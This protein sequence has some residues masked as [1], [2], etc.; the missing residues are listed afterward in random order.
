[1]SKVIKNSQDSYDILVV[2]DQVKIWD[3]IA[4]FFKPEIQ[5]GILNLEFAATG[6]ES[7][8]KIDTESNKKTDLLIID[9]ILPD[10][11]VNNE[12]FLID[13]LDRK[14]ENY[15]NKPSAFLVSAHM[16]IKN[17]E[18]LARNI[19]WIEE[20][21]I[22]P[23]DLDN[24]KTAIQKTLNLSS[25]KERF[26]IE[27][28]RLI[29]ARQLKKDV[30]EEIESEAEIILR[31]MKN[32]AA[33]V[34]DI[35]LRIN[36][37]KDKLPHGYFQKWVEIRLGCHYTTALNLLRVAQVFGDRQAELSKMGVVSS[38]LYHLATP[39]T[40]ELARTKVINLIES[41][42]KISY[43]ETKKIVRNYKDIENIE[44]QFEQPEDSPEIQQETEPT[45]NKQQVIPGIQ[46]ETEPTQNKQQI[47]K[48][49]PKKSNTEIDSIDQKSVNSQNQ[50]TELGTHRL[51]NGYPNSH[52]FQQQL[53]DKISLTIA[54]PKNNE[55][56][57]EELI[58]SRS[59]SEAIFYSPYKD[60]DIITLK[61]MVR[62]ALELYTEDKE[63]VVFSFMPDAQ[64][65]FIAE[66]LGCK[67][68]VFEPN[69]E[70]IENIL[71]LWEKRKSKV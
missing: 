46:Q 6:K 51:F 31:K 44:K 33:D 45:Q 28:N 25:E 48:I 59:K 32:T 12:S 29:E 7:L 19:D 5:D 64:L 30:F 43:R 35:G 3:E 14:F 68:F 57:K 62:N 38:I 65:L 41:G 2:E 53:P 10:T 18:K 71:N 17:L 1:L 23:L 4:D 61:I 20:I 9:V 47:V 63:N 11:P 58:P 66:S 26:N 13:L 69:E 16:S 8:N 52:I 36:K 54:F 40:P 70:V 15:Q 60:V 34:I 24:L 37:V 21:F 39:S 50:L 67:C 49:I 22:K 56:T 27:T 42:E 55:W